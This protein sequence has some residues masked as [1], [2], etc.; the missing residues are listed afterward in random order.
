MKRYCILA[1]LPIAVSLGLVLVAQAQIVPTRDAT[2]TV[3]TPNGDRLAI[4]GGQTSKDGTNL[5]HSFDRFNL[6]EHQIADFLASP[7]LRNILGRI[8]GGDVSI[9]NGLIQVTGGSPNLYLLNPAGIIFGPTA[10]LNVPAD[11]TATT[12][13]A[14]GF[15]QGA[16]LSAVGL[17]DYAN[18]VGMPHTFAF[19]TPRPSAILNAGDLAV[20]PGQRLMLLGGGVMSTGQLSTPGGEVTIA[21]VPGERLVRLSQSGHLLSLEFTAIDPTTAATL[22]TGSLASAFQ[23]PELLTGGTQGNATS[24]T[25]GADGVT[26]LAGAG[27]NAPPQP[28]AAIVMGAIDVASKGVGGSVNVVGDRVIL[29]GANINAAGVQGGGTV[30]IG[31]DLQGNGTLPNANSS[32]VDAN[33]DIQANALHQGP[34]GQ[35]IIWSDETTQVNGKLTARGGP[36][37][38]DGGLIETSGKVGLDVAGARIDARA[39]QGKPGTW[40]L[41]PSDITISDRPTDPE[42]SGPIFNPVGASAN[43]STVQI[44]STLGLGT[45]VTV[46]TGGGSGGE[47]N[48]TVQDAIIVP[49]TPGTPTLTLNA[50]NNIE[51]NAA[52]SDDSMYSNADFNLNLSAGN[53][54]T[55]NAPIATGG[56]NFSSNSTG[57][58]SNSLIETKGGAI[59]I[60]TTGS[61]GIR[62]D[63][64]LQTS[65]YQTGGGD[66]SLTADQGSIDVGAAYA[67]GILYSGID[68]SDDG[69]NI[70]ITAPQ[71]TARLAIGLTNGNGRIEIDANNAINAN[72]L[73]TGQGDVQLTSR[74]NVEV[75]GSVGTRGGNINIQGENLS[76]QP[77]VDE[78]GNIELAFLGTE[79]GEI[80]ISASNRVDLGPN[81]FIQT[82][83]G[84]FTSNSTHFAATG[85]A[86]RTR[87][88]NL[89]ITTQGTNSINIDIPIDTSGITGGNVTLS[90]PNGNIVVNSI[91]TQG[92]DGPG[93][94]V[95][96]STQRGTVQVTGIIP[97][98]LSCAGASICTLGFPSGTVSITHGG[99]PQNWDFIVGDPALNGTVG[100]IVAWSS[101]PLSPTQVFAMSAS[102][103]SVTP[104]SDITIAS[105]NAAPSFSARTLFSG[106]RPGQPLTLTFEDLLVSSSDPDQDF[107][108]IVITNFEPGTLALN[109]SPLP[110]GSTGVRISPGDTLTYTPPSSASGRVTA[111]TIAAVDPQNNTFSPFLAQS[112]PLPIQV[113]LESPP[114][115]EPPTPPVEPPTPPV[116]P[117]TPPV[118]PPTPP[119]EPP[120]P[121]V[122]PPTPPVEPPTPP[123]EPPTP[124][125]EPPTPPVEPPTPPVEPPTPPP[126]LPPDI[127]PVVL[128]PSEQVTVATVLQGVPKIVPP[129]VASVPPAPIDPIVNAIEAQFTQTFEQYLG[130]PTTPP[131][132]RV[133]LSQIRS[134]LRQVETAT[135]IKPALIYLSFVPTQLTSDR[136]ASTAPDEQLEIIVVTSK[137][138]APLRRRIANATHQQVVTVADEL[139]AA[140]ATP[141][142]TLN[143][144]Y[145]Q[146]AQQLY[147]WLIQPVLADLQ[148]QGIGNLVFIPDV[149]LRSLPYAALMQGDRFLIEDY[150]VGL[151]PSVSLT[152]L[153][154]VDPRQ[155][156]MLAMGLSESVQGQAPL[157][158]VPAEIN[159]LVSLWP[160]RS[161]LNEQFTVEQL[162]RTRSQTPYGIVHLATHA[163]INRGAIDRSYIQF[164]DRRVPLSRDQI[165]QLQLNNPP[166][167]LLGLSACRTALGDEQAELGFAGLA[168]QAGVKSALA[169]LWF[170]ND[171]ATAAL[172]A[173]FYTVLRES[174]IKA[175]ALRKAQLA[176]AK[177]EVVIAGT[178][179]QGLASGQ[180]LVLPEASLQT[181]SDRVLTHPYYWAGMTLIGNPW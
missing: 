76:L 82:E 39:P 179:V 141:D 165:R 16:W 177:G 23:L 67:D 36:D 168:V 96:L 109:G 65:N 9:I 12:A 33:S 97:S 149:R 70:T 125:V 64:I 126:A 150:S 146:P 83:G 118:E 44:T 74:G 78:L 58:N 11:F 52:I 25:V 50:D 151:M 72:S 161:Y 116:E 181:L 53:G 59:D 55:I 28:G 62:I 158:A 2:G 98:S 115:V 130:T 121:P 27:V 10:R 60:I 166:V 173:D 180:T 8:I 103:S 137:E 61:S 87:G 3:V 85:S 20:P 84:D 88:G 79:G 49:T 128:S 77:G 120:T 104:A 135:G 143:Q 127:P 13:T 37:G 43:V 7:Q 153:R 75:V 26:R 81:A 95:T 132:P 68:S 167:E 144:A 174:P 112:S 57:F 47:G 30:R 139:R 66:I 31:G 140:V 111:F 100:S 171:A 38:G 113:D 172:M 136:S 32:Y 56:G 19:M 14:I 133:T 122:E 1:G 117:P 131:T 73:S 164:W 51:I 138:G 108:A 69:G 160:G 176:M 90:S 4:Q 163:D 46:T 18:L 178:Q 99:G 105:V 110:A 80:Q 92:L 42:M 21:A 145:R 41:D 86:F 106:A 89:A 134:A 159:K 175:E 45:N 71:G 54:I 48:I 93:G 170:I 147:Q 17:P 148:Q 152:D 94:N 157:P 156:A 155:T 114:P 40:L 123:V 154:Y 22:P 35:I 102:N 124:P 142:Q 162:Q 63:S 129:I 29:T 169:S 15:G 24:L 101:D 5:F 34:G 91:N 6:S 119:V 107:V